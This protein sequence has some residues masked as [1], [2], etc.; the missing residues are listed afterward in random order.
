MLHLRTE[1]FRILCFVA[2]LSCAVV[3]LVVAAFVFVVV[4][5]RARSLVR[6]QPHELASGKFGSSKKTELF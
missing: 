3:S 4:L 1:I 5:C 2:L 6:H